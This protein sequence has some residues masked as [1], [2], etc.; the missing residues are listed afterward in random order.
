MPSTSDLIPTIRYWEKTTGHAVHSFEPLEEPTKQ[1]RLIRHVEDDKWDMANFNLDSAPPY[2]AL[3]YTWGIKSSDADVV[4]LDNQV[5]ATP[6]TLSRFFATKRSK[7]SRESWLWVDQISIDQDETDE[8]SKQ[9]SI[10]AE[11]YRRADEVV[12]WLDG[13]SQ[14]TCQVFNIEV[15]SLPQKLNAHRSKR[16]LGATVELFRHRY[17]SR[18]WTVQEMLFAKQISIV[19]GSGSITFDQVQR[20]L[21]FCERARWGRVWWSSETA[22][23]LRWFVKNATTL[24]GASDAELRCLDDL[25]DVFSDSGCQDARDKVYGLAGLLKSDHRPTIDYYHN[26]SQVFIHAVEL[27][28]RNWHNTRPLRD[29]VSICFKLAA[30]MMPKQMAVHEIFD[31]IDVFGR[32]LARSKDT[33]I[34]RI[35]Q[36][37]VSAFEDFV[38]SLKVDRFPFFPERN[39]RKL[40]RL[41]DKR[42]ARIQQDPDYDMEGEGENF[43]SESESDS[44]SD[45][46][47]SD[48]DAE[49][50]ESDVSASA[51]HEIHPGAGIEAANMDRKEDKQAHEP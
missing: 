24:H 22:K 26:V 8:R 20:V 31:R 2:R 33:T 42:I 9:V 28:T 50:V 44:A 45:S 49:D 12:V 29:L 7:A 32:I 40:E 36:D 30:Q 6:K 16:I 27:L 3:S 1:V 51:G 11:V 5:F 34:D 37:I 17:W 46:E 13:L 19:Y 41:S 39:I 38:D 15:D 14:E 47:M 4:I 10:M 43:E 35:K 18:I 25:I 48:S 21:E 23:K